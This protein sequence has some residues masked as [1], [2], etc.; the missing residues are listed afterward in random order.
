M[1][2]LYLLLLTLALVTACD[3]TPR[4]VATPSD[5]DTITVVATTTMLHDL[6]RQVGGDRIHAVGIMKPGGD[7]HL[8]QPTP[9]DARLIASSA[10]VVT[11]GLYLEG[12]IDDLVRN[13][14]GTRPVVVASARVEPIRMEGSIGGVDPH[15]WFDLNAWNLA[16]DEVGAQLEQLLTPDE[17]P[18]LRE[19]VAA[20]RATIERLE[21]WSRAQLSS[22][23]RTQRVLV[24]SHD[25][26]NYF[27]RSFEIDVVAI[28]GLSTEQEASQ[29]DL[30]NVIETV[31]ARNAPAVF[32]ETS[33]N[34]RLI[35][36]VA[37]ETGA[38]V[39]GPLHS[40]SLGP[41][42]GPAETF[43]GMFVDNVTMIVTELGGAVSPF[44][45]S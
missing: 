11:S 23:D 14:G 22:V 2:L 34:P 45:G 40:D 21:A 17:V 25:A 24:T 27:G 20:Y 26:F 6:V 19:R 44:E 33:V 32:V 30:A 16:V 8:Y 1:H 7:P 13:A 36:Q 4:N 12:W 28:Q 10:M 3:K 18:A 43:V 39:A 42:G 15:F 29:R 38:K 41:A 9:S 37:R 31:R 5:T 35:Q